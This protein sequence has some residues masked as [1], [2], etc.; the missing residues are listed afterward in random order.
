MGVKKE[1][2]GE[3]SYVEKPNCSSKVS[4]WDGLAVLGRTVL[5]L[6]S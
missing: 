1:I 6:E 3:E 4:T 2:G 5:V